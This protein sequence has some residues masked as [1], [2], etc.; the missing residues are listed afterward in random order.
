MV[1][2]PDLIGRVH[3]VDMSARDHERP[4]PGRF[5]R[6]PQRMAKARAFARTAEPHP[7]APSP[8]TSVTIFG[9]Q[10]RFRS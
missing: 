5:K 8:S 2:R 1:G 9:R 3:P 6:K 10:I 4:A 7:Y